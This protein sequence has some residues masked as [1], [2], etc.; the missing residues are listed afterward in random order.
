MLESERESYSATVT[1]AELQYRYI[2]MGQAHVHITLTPP[3]P[4]AI[5]TLANADVETGPKLH[6][7]RG[8]K[9]FGEDVAELG[10]G[11]DV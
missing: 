6:K 2:L 10:G 1:L 5:E 9:P 7:H 3:P 8:W 4:T 11:R